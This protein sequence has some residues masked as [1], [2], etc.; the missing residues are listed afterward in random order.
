MTWVQVFRL[1]ALGF[2]ASAGIIVLALGARIVALVPEQDA[3]AFELGN[4]ETPEVLGIVIGVLTTLTALVMLVVDYMR[5]DAFTSMVAVEIVWASVVGFLWLAEVVITTNNTPGPPGFV[6][7]DSDDPSTLFEQVC[8]DALA[9]SCI[10]FVTWFVL[11]GYAIALLIFALLNRSRGAH[12]IWTS[13]VKRHP[14][15]LPEK[16]PAT[17]NLD[18]PLVA[19]ELPPAQHPAPQRQQQGQM[20][21]YNVM[22]TPQISYT[23]Y[24]PGATVGYS[25]HPQL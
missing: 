24:G 5:T 2:S 23:S 8:N 3:V 7:C 13:S 15:V 16:E 21:A 4:S 9:M 6:T 20:H 14:F 1:F 12:A 17:P 11:H 25:G 22:P 10:A 18:L 19:R